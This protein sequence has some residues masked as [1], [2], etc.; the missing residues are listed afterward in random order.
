MPQLIPTP[1]FYILVFSWMV[2]T[3]ILPTKVMAHKFNNEPNPQ[4]TE[5]PLPL[6]W[7]WSWH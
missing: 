5:K 7:N 1:W 4:T 2:F 3:A 6:P